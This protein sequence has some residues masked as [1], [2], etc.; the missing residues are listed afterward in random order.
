MSIF[1]IQNLDFWC[2]FAS[3]IRTNQDYFG[4][5]RYVEIFNAEKF[6]GDVNNFE[7]A[8]S[9][10]AEAYYFLGQDDKAIE[11]LEIWEKYINT[12]GYSQ[13]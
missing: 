8:A 9:M 6:L 2:D 7:F 4:Y 11:N 5:E 12:R 3:K 1:L 13:F 10:L